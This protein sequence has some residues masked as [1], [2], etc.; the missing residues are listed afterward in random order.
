M[1]QLESHA[2]L[3]GRSAGRDTQ[4]LIQGRMIDSVGRTRET[5]E[6]FAED[7][8][9]QKNRADAKT[10]TLNLGGNEVLISFVLLGLADV[11]DWR[12]VDIAVRSSGGALGDKDFRARSILCWNWKGDLVSEGD[13]RDKTT[14]QK[15]F[16]LIRK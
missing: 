6:V 3:G 8:A 5:V 16:C 7:R 1:T 14:G 9:R 12:L 10:S 13:V 2:Q 11:S 4:D 15:K